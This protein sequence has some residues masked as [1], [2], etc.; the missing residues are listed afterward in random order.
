MHAGPCVDWKFQKLLTHRHAS[1]AEA[2]DIRQGYRKGRMIDLNEATIPRITENEEPGRKRYDVRSEI[3]G[4]G[5][6]TRAMIFM[7]WTERYKVRL[8]A[9][10]TRNTEVLSGPGLP[11]PANTLGLTA[12]VLTQSSRLGY[13]HEIVKLGP[14][15]LV[16]CSSFSSSSFGKRTCQPTFPV[17]VGSHP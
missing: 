12:P 15:T 1:K 6:A 3:V 5:E 11:L 13:G 8:V 17:D 7:R 4:G 14:G 2:E 9:G 16:F 10:R